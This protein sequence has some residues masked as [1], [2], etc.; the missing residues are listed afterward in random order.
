[1]NQ[2]DKEKMKLLNEWDAVCELV[3][4][5]LEKIGHDILLVPPLEHVARSK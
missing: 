4:I 2:T 5:G 3:R 1:M